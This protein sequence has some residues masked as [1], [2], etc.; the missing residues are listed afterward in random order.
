MQG[1]LICPYHEE[2]TGYQKQN[3]KT[4]HIQKKERPK[5]KSGRYERNE[6]RTETT[7]RISRKTAKVVTVR[8]PFEVNADKFSHSDREMS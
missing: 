8:T 1:K 3:K 5:K 6:P 7:R 4:Y 2:Q